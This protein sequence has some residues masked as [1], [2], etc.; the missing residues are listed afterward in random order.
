[1]A[2]TIEAH[3]TRSGKT[4]VHNNGEDFVIP[5]PIRGLMTNYGYMVADPSCPTRS[6]IWFSGGSMEVQDEVNDAEIWKQIFDESILPRRDPKSMAS[7]LAAKLLLGAYTTTTTTAADGTTSTTHDVDGQR[8][9]GPS[10][11]IFTNSDG[12]DEESVPMMSYYFKRPIGGHGEV[13]C[14]LL[15]VD[16]TLRIMQGHHQS[17]YVFTRVPTV[18]A[19]NVA[20]HT[21]DSFS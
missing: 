3:Q 6:S 2:F 21:E 12:A 1:V 4:L 13:F 11:P 5:R 18:E 10:S 8:S 19:I 17:L 20:E 7:L 15:Y 9:S 16:E 14:D